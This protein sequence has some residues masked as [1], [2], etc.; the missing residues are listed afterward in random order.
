MNVVRNAH[1][2]WRFRRASVDHG[3]THRDRAP[4]Y[5]AGLPVPVSW[6][7]MHTAHTGFVLPPWP[8]R[9]P[10]VHSLSTSRAGTTLVKSEVQSSTPPCLHR[11]LLPKSL[12]NARS[13]AASKVRNYRILN[14][15]SCHQ[16]SWTSLEL[17]SSLSALLVTRTD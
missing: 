5:P 3:K 14:Y 15:V 4:K 8:K 7:T 6:T 13:S 1:R 16:T 10:T 12:R 11:H 17:L 9:K 2:P